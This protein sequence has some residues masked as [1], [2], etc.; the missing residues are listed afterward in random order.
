MKMATLLLAFA[1]SCAGV[2]ALPRP[3]GVPVVWAIVSHAVTCAQSYFIEDFLDIY[4]VFTINGTRISTPS[5][6]ASNPYD[7][8]KLPL[9]DATVGTFRALN[10]SN[11]L[12]SDW[13]GMLPTHDAGKAAYNQIPLVNRSANNFGGLGPN[14]GSYCHRT[15]TLTIP[16]YAWACDPGNY[17]A[18]PN[19]VR[20]NDVVSITNLDGSVQRIG[21]RIDNASEYRT[22]TPALNGFNGFNFQLNL[23]PL[24]NASA[25]NPGSEQSFRFT[26]AYMQY[27]LGVPPFLAQGYADDF[28]GFI[29]AALDINMLDENMNTVSLFYSFFDQETGARRA[30]GVHDHLLRFRPGVRRWRQGLHSRVDVHH[31]L[32]DDVPL[33][34]HLARE[35]LLDRH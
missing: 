29:E 26:A 27:Y 19:F 33:L 21:M 3:A 5:Q 18:H 14:N 32:Y 28:N 1:S 12:V 13:G 34:D 22:A 23:Q 31:Q 8:A 20:I 7:L 10:I 24:R 16:A 30:R 9:G 15:E 4:D 2:S 6:R 25:G 17:G 11:G 35:E